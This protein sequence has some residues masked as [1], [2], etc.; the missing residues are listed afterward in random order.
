MLLTANCA[1]QNRAGDSSLSTV[2]SAQSSK[3][4]LYHPPL[5]EA[6]FVNT[7]KALIF[8]GYIHELIS[9]RSHPLLTEDGGK[10]WIRM[11]YETISFEAVNFINS[12][13][14]WAVSENSQL[15]RTT[16][17]GSTWILIS[18]L[19]SN[20]DQIWGLSPTQIQFIDENEGWVL[21]PFFL[22]HTQDGGNSWEKKEFDSGIVRMQFQGRYTGWIGGGTIPYNKPNVIY[23]T[24]NGGITWEQIEIP[25][26]N[27]GSDDIRDIFFID[28]QS[29]WIANTRGIYHTDDGGMTWQKQILPEQTN[30]SMLGLTTG[31]VIE[32]INFIN[33]E[34]GWAAGARVITYDESE[35]VLLHTTDGGRSWQEINTGIKGRRFSKVFFAD[36]QNGWLVGEIIVFSLDK[37]KTNI[38]RTEDG[39]KTWKL[40]LT[41]K[42]PYAESK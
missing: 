37:D 2:K 33:G 10:T 24:K 20:L 17:G 22:L 15:W 23:R 1:K 39:G 29:G 27:R 28:E 7:D 6:I 14:G 34:E 42:S 21:Y 40:V 13:Q 41:L 5:R 19:V 12:L 30:V 8:P 25:N 16:D 36:N 26:T 31:I 18:N 3:T 35:A 9:E 38:Y 4:P 11:Q 32:S